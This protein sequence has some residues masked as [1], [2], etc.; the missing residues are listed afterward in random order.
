MRRVIG[1]GCAAGVAAAALGVLSA[2]G[3]AFAAPAG[4]A[5][6][7]C[8]SATY[9]VH[10]YAPGTGRTVALTFDD[11]PGRATNR[12]VRELV[13]AHVTATFF[14]LGVHEVDQPADVRTERADGFA[15]GDHTWD[16][17]D[18][19]LLGAGGQAREIDRE[20]RA[21]TA[22]TGA[23][24]CLF[25]PP[26]GSFDATT[27][28]LAQERGMQVWNWSVDTEDWKADGSDDLYWV[29]RIVSRA[30]AGSDQQHPVI[31]MHNQTG[32]NPATADAL[33][34]IINYYRALGYRFVDLYGHTG[35]PVVSRVSPASGP[36]SGGTR[37]TVT[38][39]D[40][41]G[42]VRVRFGSVAGTSVVVQSSTRLLVTSPARVPMRVD[43]R[44]ETTLG[45]SQARVVDRFTYVAPGH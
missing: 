12:I 35:H 9:G 28:K 10:N 8:P 3:V 45:T 13:A 17:Q 22:I 27:L 23:N 14:N 15:L 39:H 26:F 40:F 19:T 44:V 7:G 32:G 6:T 30:E 37:V 5:P 4:A 24:P 38:G 36:T 41:V 31:L 34:T 42:R 2:V 25:R 16:H 18:L 43:V 29:D 21:Q 20:R 1:R 11:G 33:P